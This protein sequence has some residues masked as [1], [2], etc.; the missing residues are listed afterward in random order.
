MSKNL[1]DAIALTSAIICMSI[2]REE[3]INQNHEILYVLF[4]A[5]LRTKDQVWI[6][7]NRNYL[8]FRQ[9]RLQIAGL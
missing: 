2:F 7:E 5:T 9:A 6:I 3:G 8:I 4:H 1:T